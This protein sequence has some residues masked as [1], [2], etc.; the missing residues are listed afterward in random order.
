MTENEKEILEL[1]MERDALLKQIAGDPEYTLYFYQRKALRQRD[2][3]DRLNRR[4]VTQRFVL[5]TLEE[6]GRG[7]SKDE[8]L[9][10]REAVENEQLRERIDEPA[11]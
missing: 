4:V 11:K 1:K 7:L 10:A 5:R 3:L 6:L 8:Y 2:A 9:K